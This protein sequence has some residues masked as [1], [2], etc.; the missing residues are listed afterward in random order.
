MLAAFMAVCVQSC[1]K[2]GNYI[3]KET[4]FVSVQNSLSIQ[5]DTIDVIGNLA[6]RH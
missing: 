3:K 1:K 6:K 4:N 2:G 5:S